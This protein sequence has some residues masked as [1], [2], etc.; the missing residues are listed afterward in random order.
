M[1]NFRNYIASIFYWIATKI[2][3]RTVEDIKAQLTRYEERLKN[4]K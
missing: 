4:Y 1:K 2:D 3:A